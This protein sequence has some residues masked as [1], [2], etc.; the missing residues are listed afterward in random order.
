MLVLG[1]YI[2]LNTP[3]ALENHMKSGVA[4]IEKGN[5]QTEIKEKSPISLALETEWSSLQE[6]LKKEGELL[7]GIQ[8]GSTT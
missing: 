4:A 7:Y 3:L 8:N 1:A 5:L 6:K 2:Y